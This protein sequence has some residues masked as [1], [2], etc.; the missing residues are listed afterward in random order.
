MKK[1]L[2]WEFEGRWQRAECFP[3]LGDVV[4]TSDDN[5]DAEFINGV[6]IVLSVVHRPFENK[7]I[8]TLLATE[9]RHFLKHYYRHDNPLKLREF[10]S[11]V[12]LL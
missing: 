12:G 7:S 8:V 1:L 10:N 5:Y 4:L 6:A 3:Q 11:E 2:Q 9:E